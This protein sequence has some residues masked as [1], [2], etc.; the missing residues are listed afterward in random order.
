MNLPPNVSETFEGIGRTPQA[1]QY[2]TSNDFHKIES[3]K[4]TKE[5]LRASYFKL[6]SE[7]DTVYQ[8]RHMI[9]TRMEILLNQGKD[10]QAE[11]DQLII[12]SSHL[13]VWLNHITKRRTQF[14]TQYVQVIDSLK[15]L[16]DRKAIHDAN[17][18]KIKLEPQP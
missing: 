11:M 4:E 16:L 7:R 8:R 15:V 2:F 12:E 10:A 13:N 1:Q 5:T 14:H 9:E 6:V 17:I 3:L 18:D